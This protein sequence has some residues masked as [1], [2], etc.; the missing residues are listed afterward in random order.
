M[1]QAKQRNPWETSPGTK[2]QQV[3][4]LSPTPQHKHMASCDNQHHADT[5]LPHLLTLL[6]HS[7]VLCYSRSAPF[8]QVYLTPNSGRTILQGIG[9]V[10][11]LLTPPY[12]GPPLLTIAALP[13]STLG[14]SSSGGCH[15]LAV[16]KHLDRGQH[17]FQVTLTLQ[18]GKDNHKI[19]Q[20]EGPA[21]GWGRQ[22]VCLQALPTN[23]SSGD[24]TGKV[25]CYCISGKRLVWL[26]SVG[27]WCETSPLTTQGPS[28][29][30]NRQTVCL[31][32]KTIRLKEKATQPQQQDMH[33]T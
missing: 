15:S 10:Q 9:A 19:S 31:P 13:L 17:H 7:P 3:P 18:R 23:K 27:R 11:T 32:L 29:P 6:P 21:V 25:W 12:H 26:N 20:T 1:C 28:T 30:H 8:R 33:N 22:L 14:Q 5:Q 24:N 4:C 2:E 16:C